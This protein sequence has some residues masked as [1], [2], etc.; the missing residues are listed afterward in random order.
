MQRKFAGAPV[1]VV[2]D[3]QINQEIVCSVLEDIGFIPECANNGRIAIEMAGRNRYALILMDMLMP[4][5]DGVD[6]TLVLRRMPALDTVPILALTAS[7]FDQDRERCL[8]A[9]M[10]AKLASPAILTGS[11]PGSGPH[12]HPVETG[13]RRAGL[14]VAPLHRRSVHFLGH[15]V[16]P[17]RQVGGNHDHVVR[18]GGAIQL[19]H[20]LP[21]LKLDPPKGRRRRGRIQPERRRVNSLLSF[22]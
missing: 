21:G 17:I 9:G 18:T 2:E 14:R 20:G 11:T 15:H 8:A 13:G 4:E 1:L 10:P 3:N 16:A 5:M 12:A 6:A 7:A 19:E 22:P